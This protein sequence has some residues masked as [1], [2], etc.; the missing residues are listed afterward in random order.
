MRRV[1][2][3]GHSGEA[4]CCGPSI[5]LNHAGANGTYLTRKQIIDYYCRRKGKGAMPRGRKQPDE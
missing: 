1:D 4:A 5:D 2:A 3:Y